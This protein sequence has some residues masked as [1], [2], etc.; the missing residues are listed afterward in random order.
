MKCYS[1]AKSLATQAELTVPRQQ[2]Q[3]IGTG[4][5]RK[6]CSVPT[7]VATSNGELLLDHKITN[8]HIELVT[9]T[10]TGYAI[11]RQTGLGDTRQFSVVR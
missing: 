10:D 11:D 3:K 7:G 5:E 4:G 2:Q 9:K 6:C 1:C 8:V